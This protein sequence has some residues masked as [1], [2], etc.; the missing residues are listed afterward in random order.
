MRGVYVLDLERSRQFVIAA[1]HVQDA[2]NTLTILLKNYRLSYKFEGSYHYYPFH[3]DETEYDAEKR[4]YLIMAK[5]YGIQYLLA[6]DTLLE[7]IGKGTWTNEMPLK[8]LVRNDSETSVGNHS[9]DKGV[10]SISI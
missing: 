7:S 10:F 9:E 3:K 4:I 2:E 6:R 8:N 1:N 5:H